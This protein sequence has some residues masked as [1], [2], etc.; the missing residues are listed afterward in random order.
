MT[1]NANRGGLGQRAIVVGAGMG[2]MMAAQVLSRY[3]DN[4]TVLERDVLPSGPEPR[5]GVP[6]GQHVHALL[7]QGRRNLETLFPSFTS[8]LMD[9]GAMCSRMGL[10][11]RIHDGVGWQPTRDLNLP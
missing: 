11:F 3:F 8:E 10:E 7:V 6:Q 2:G 9:R 4:V 5:M 1:D